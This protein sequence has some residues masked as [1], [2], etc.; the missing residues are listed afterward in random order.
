[1]TATTEYD[2]P[3]A[4][5]AE[6]ARHP[7]TE[8]PY[9]VSFKTRNSTLISIRGRD[10]E[11]LGERL[12]LLSAPVG[13][14]GDSVLDMISAIDGSLHGGSGAA[15]APFEGGQVQQQRSLTPPCEACGGDTE[16]RSGTSRSSG[17][18]Y[19]GYFCTVNRDHKP[20]FVN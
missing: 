6:L 19:K 11:E 13:R 12:G 2:S 17:K 7:D 14:E 18:A 9:S 4:L 16:L 5:A 8:S 15:S 20:K 10:A 1:M 3:E